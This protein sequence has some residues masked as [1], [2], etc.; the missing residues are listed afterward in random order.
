[1]ERLK[2]LMEKHN[3]KTQYALAKG[4]GIDYKVVNHWFTGR[5]TPGEDNL[6]KLASFFHV[7]PEWLRYGK[8]QDAPTLD[9]EAQMLAGE[10]A[11][12]GPEGIKK[13]RQILKIFFEGTVPEK[14]YTV[15]KNNKKQ[16]SA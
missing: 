2:L 11:R 12:Y 1:M 14:H 10:I 16:R 9:T 3:I 15:Q 4:A 8:E 13:A 7:R 5:A 6:F